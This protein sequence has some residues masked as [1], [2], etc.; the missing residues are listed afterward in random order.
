MSWFTSSVFGVGVLTHNLDFDLSTSS[1][2]H[3]LRAVIWLGLDWE[4]ESILEAFGIW[5]KERPWFSLDFEWPIEDLRTDHQLIEEAML[6][7]ELTSS[8]D[9]NS[10][11]SL[12]SQESDFIEKSP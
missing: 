3:D 10:K 5:G 11:D 7:L 12:F 9:D 1:L 8:Y 4:F 2:I 6:C